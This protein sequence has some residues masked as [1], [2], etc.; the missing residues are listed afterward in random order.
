MKT[1]ISFLS[2]AIILLVSSISY[3]KGSISVIRDEETE[4]FLKDVTKPILSAA[5]LDFGS[6]EIIIVN[7]KSINAFVSSGQKIF[8]HTGL[9]AECPDV[10]CLIGVIAHEAGHIKGGHI[11]RKTDSYEDANLSTIAGYI[12]G[13][14][15]VL[16]GAPPE[17]GIAISSAGQNVAMRKVLST[18]RDYENSADS[19]AL[20]VMDK[21][22]INPKGLVAILEKLRQ[23]QSIAG[24]IHDKYML[25]HP[26]SQERISHIENY[27]LRNPK[28]DR[29]IPRDI[30]DRF[31]MIKAKI[32]GFLYDPS[33]TRSLYPDINSKEAIYANAIALHK[34]AQFDKSLS[35]LKKLKNF[36]FS[37]PYV[38]ELE[39]Q[40]LFERGEVS[41]SANKYREVLNSLGNS[42][43]VRL[44][45]ANALINLQNEKSIREAIGQ[46]KA[47][48]AIEPNNV[49]AINKLGIA[50]GKLGN[51]EESYIYL[52]ESAIISKKLDNAK[53]YLAK[54]EQLLDKSSENYSR[55]TTLKEEAKKLIG[56]K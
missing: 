46:L 27:M 49:N 51:L 9:I 5:D 32:Y 14:G 22:K 34:E 29:A 17:A 38:K 2:I 40:F 55:L 6:V 52:A 53:F 1:L 56:K 13:L 44:K 12:L 54:A 28:T 41:K 19:V 42:N 3:S 43:L 8:I 47:I 16:A 50:Y 37:S 26:I 39:A 48:L 24:D 45:L 30:N 31:N 21:I 33:V 7:D 35:M 4:K 11:I 15:S 36:G 23:K 20:D 18:S 25:T 10:T